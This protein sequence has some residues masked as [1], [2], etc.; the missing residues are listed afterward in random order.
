M[1]KFLHF[2]F[3]QSCFS[4]ARPHNKISA[5]PK[6]A[7]KSTTTTTLNPTPLYL[8]LLCVLERRTTDRTLLPVSWAARRLASEKQAYCWC[9]TTF[10]ASAVCL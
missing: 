5:P 7:D 1:T 10:A 4:T 3:V 2:V 8:Y 9:A 6:N